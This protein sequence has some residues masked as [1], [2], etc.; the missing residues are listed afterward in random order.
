MKNA[1][2]TYIPPDYIRLPKPGA[3][4]AISGLSRTT[5]I[6]LSV[7]SRCN[8]FRPPVESKHIKRA[9][10]QRGIRL[11]SRESLLAYLKQLEA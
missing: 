10:A 7:P 2:T 4:C 1:I 9:G 6:E 5:L 8:D 3:R 11:I